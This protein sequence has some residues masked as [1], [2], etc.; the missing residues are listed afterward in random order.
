M[1]AKSTYAQGFAALQQKLQRL[2]PQLMQ[3]VAHDVLPSAQAQTPVDSGELVNSEHVEI[4][5]T[6]ATLVADAPHALWVHEDLQADHAQG[7][8]RFLT[9]AAEVDGPLAVTRTMTNRLA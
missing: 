8:A 3:E 9:N 7:N 6:G 1:V 4:T 2:A 5:P